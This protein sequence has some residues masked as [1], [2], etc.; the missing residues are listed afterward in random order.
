MLAKGLLTRR[1]LIIPAVKTTVTNEGLT[2]RQPKVIGINPSRIQISWLLHYQW[3]NQHKTPKENIHHIVHR[4]CVSQ[5][6]IWPNALA[7]QMQLIQP[8]L[9][10]NYQMP[11]SAATSAKLWHQGPQDDHFRPYI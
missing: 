3:K 1:S 11:S 7:I 8:N 2:K 6:H 4:S 5:Q 9:A 10:N